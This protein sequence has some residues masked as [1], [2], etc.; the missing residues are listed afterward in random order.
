MNINKA[1][2]LKNK[3]NLSF[4]PSNFLVIADHLQLPPIKLHCSMLAEEAIQHAINNFLKKSQ[5]KK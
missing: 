5:G 1:K 4:T 3:G 2:L